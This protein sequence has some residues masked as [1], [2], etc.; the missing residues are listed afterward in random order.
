MNQN[1][2]AFGDLKEIIQLKIYSPEISVHIYSST[3]QILNYQVLNKNSKFLN[4]GKIEL[5]KGFNTV[6]LPTF[7]DPN[8]SL[9]QIKKIGFEVKNYDDGK[10]Y[11]NKGKYILKSENKTIDFSVN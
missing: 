8:L 4:G 1:I 9:K 3:S 7:I 11:L 2:Q 10:T 5:D 6:N